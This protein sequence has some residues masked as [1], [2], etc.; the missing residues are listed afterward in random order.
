MHLNS[1]AIS[2]VQVIFLQRA[3]CWDAD[4]LYFTAWIASEHNHHSGCGHEELMGETYIHSAKAVIIHVHPRNFQQ[5][6]AGMALP[7][8]PEH[9]Q[10]CP[11]CK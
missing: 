6:H 3:E 9:Q 7:L 2:L 11:E 8:P 4:I 5:V 10:P 1:R